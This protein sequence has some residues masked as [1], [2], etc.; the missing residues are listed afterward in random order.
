MEPV[1]IAAGVREGAGLL[2]VVRVPLA[3]TRGDPPRVDQ[4][5]RLLVVVPH[6]TPV[7]A[8]LDLLRD[9]RLRRLFITMAILTVAW[10]VYGFAIP[11]HGTNIGLSAS[12]IGLV[13]ATF[14]AATFTVRLA[15]PFFINR[16]HPW[17]VLVVSLFVAGIS[18]E[19]LYSRLYS[20]GRFALLAAVLISVVLTARG[21]TGNTA[22]TSRRTAPWCAAS[23]RST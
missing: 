3:G 21:W 8:I 16:I 23:R 19:I 5:L 15:T 7:G 6:D 17:T 20:Y 2:R 13:M 10:D 12:E 9:V 14:A 4:F 18:F 1:E 11:V 22:R